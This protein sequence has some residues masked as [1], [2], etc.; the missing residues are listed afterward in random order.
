MVLPVVGRGG[1]PVGDAAV[2]LNVTVTDPQ[3]A[4]FV[5]VYP[6]GSALPMASNLNYVAGSTVPNAVMAKVGDG[7]QVCVFTQS[8]TNLVVDV[9]GYFPV[10]S[11]YASL[12]PARLL[13]RGR[14]VDGGWAVRWDGVRGAGSVTELPV[15]GRGG[16]PVVMRLR[17]C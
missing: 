17:W 7:G 2:V 16:V 4:G 14:C 3:A 5:T 11:G 6:C 12:V 13:D 1:V 9:S 15:V 8:A 10:G